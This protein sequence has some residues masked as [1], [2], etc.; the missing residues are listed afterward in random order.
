MLQTKPVAVLQRK[1][2]FATARFPLTWKRVPQTRHVFLWAGQVLLKHC[3]A[4]L[5]RTMP[6]QYIVFLNFTGLWAFILGQL[7]V[8]KQ[9][10]NI[11]F[12]FWFINKGQTI[13]YNARFEFHCVAAL[14]FLDCR[15]VFFTA[16]LDQCC[17]AI[18][19]TTRVPWTPWSAWIC[20]TCQ[21]PQT[22]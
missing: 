9:R 4:G 20:Q 2:Y 6:L 1:P 21:H 18:Q 12:R 17:C 5:Y 11:M 7:K 10:F 15:I 19:S 22:R 13:S 8:G 16:T 14:D 3:S